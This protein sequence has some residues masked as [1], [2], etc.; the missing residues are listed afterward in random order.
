MSSKCGKISVGI[1]STDDSINFKDGCGFLMAKILSAPPY[2]SKYNL[3]I[4]L[5]KGCLK[6]GL[7][8]SAYQERYGEPNPYASFLTDMN[9]KCVKIKICQL[10]ITNL[11][12]KDSELLPFVKPVAYMED[13]IIQFQI[14][15]DHA[16]LYA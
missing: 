11:G 4:L 15:K 5:H 10:C 9:Q 14:K 6:Y 13:Y 8:N 12:F 3:F 16:I 7:T 2:E 1:S